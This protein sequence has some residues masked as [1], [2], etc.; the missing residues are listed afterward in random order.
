MNF[1]YR[2]PCQRR[3]W[4]FDDAAKTSEGRSAIVRAAVLIIRIIAVGSHAANGAVR[5]QARIPS[6]GS[7]QMITGFGTLAK[8]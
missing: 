3:L 1:S 4:A 7:G 6:H 8:Y 2:I 5:N